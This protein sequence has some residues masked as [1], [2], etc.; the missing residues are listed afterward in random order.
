MRNDT[1]SSPARFW[2]TFSPAPV[3]R[4]H[5]QTQIA[6]KVVLCSRSSNPNLFIFHFRQTI[7][8]G[9][10]I[11]ESDTLLSLVPFDT[12]LPRNISDPPFLSHLYLFGSN[13]CSTSSSCTPTTS[14]TTIVGTF[15]GRCSSRECLLDASIVREG[16]AGE[17]VLSIARSRFEMVDSDVVEGP[18]RSIPR[19]S[20]VRIRSCGNETTGAR[21]GAGSDFEI[22]LRGC[23]TASGEL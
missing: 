14:S 19:S 22:L 10:L 12:S 15:E 17:T 20:K 4:Q 2:V 8:L 9:P 3:P 7:L 6:V 23:G 5:V 13:R 21:E 1:G 16:G 18:V 11:P